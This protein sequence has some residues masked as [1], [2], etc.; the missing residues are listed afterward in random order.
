MNMYD[1]IAMILTIMVMGTAAI[2]SI[3]LLFQCAYGYMHTYLEG[4]YKEERYMALAAM[5]MHDDHVY[6]TCEYCHETMV[7]DHAHICAFFGESD[8]ESILPY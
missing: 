6:T 7:D 2:F 8:L 3:G 4:S 1:I 5:L